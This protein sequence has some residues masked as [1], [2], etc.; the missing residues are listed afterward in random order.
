MRR[1]APAT[2]PSGSVNVRASATVSAMPSRVNTPKD[3]A[4]AR[5]SCGTTRSTGM[6]SARRT[7]AARTSPKRVNN[8]TKPTAMRNITSRPRTPSVQAPGTSATRPSGKTAGT[9]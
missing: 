8:G 9:T 5:A 3:T 2:A 1:S 6:P 7:T 4:L